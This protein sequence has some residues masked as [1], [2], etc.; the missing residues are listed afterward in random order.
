M[1]AV[2]TNKKMQALLAEI[3]AAYDFGQFT[4]EGFIHWLQQRRDRE[5]L[6]VPCHIPSPTISG[7]WLAGDNRDFIFFEKNT[8]PIHQT[9]IQLHEMAH[10][11]CGHP[12]LKI[13][14]ADFQ[15]AFR[16]STGINRAEAMSS[17]LLHSHSNETEFEAETLA[18]LIQE[19]VLRYG[20]L[21]EL[22]TVL[23][24]D[25]TR[26]LEEFI[27]SFELSL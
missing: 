3:E 20:R 13:S 12:T 5:I 22:T 7:A 4:M 23:H 8:P 16:R 9:H 19:K 21:R 27:Q 6:F 14:A 17:L 25:F 15:I 1:E 10:M 26:F 11:L 18:S 2:T 24:S